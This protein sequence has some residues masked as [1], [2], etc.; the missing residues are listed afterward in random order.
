ML[1]IWFSILMLFGL[2]II[3]VVRYWSVTVMGVILIVSNMIIIFTLHQDSSRV[4]LWGFMIHILVYILAV[5]AVSF[6]FLDFLNGSVFY[7]GI[8]ALTTVVFT[9]VLY[10][11]WKYYKIC[12]ERIEKELEH[13]NPYFYN[14]YDDE[15]TPEADKYLFDVALVNDY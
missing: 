9:T 14:G 4:R 3:I 2:F 13:Q 5:V 6:Y 1:S 12:K 7:W 11:H 10:S 15:N 8:V